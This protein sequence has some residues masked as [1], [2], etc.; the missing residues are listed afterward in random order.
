MLD[1]CSAP[2][3]KSIQI[4]QRLNNT[5][6]LVANE[7]VY[8]RAKILYENIVRFGYKNYIVSSNL[9]SVF[10]N[11]C[12]LY[13]KILIDAPCSG[14]GMFRKSS[15]D[16]YSWSM[17]NVEA[18]SNR[19]YEILQSVSKALKVGGKLVYSTCTY[20]IEE[21][22]KVV[23]RFL[24]ANPDYV[25][26]P[27]P[28]NVQDSTAR[29][30]DV[31]GEMTHMCGRRYP[32]LHKGEG[33]FVALMQRVGENKD[34]CPPSYPLASRKDTQYIQSVL[35]P[36]VDTSDMRFYT[37]GDNVYVVPD[38]DMDI[39]GM[40]VTSLGVYVGVVTKKGVDI[41]HSFYKAYGDRFYNKV[42]LSE[43]EANVYITGNV[44]DVPSANPGICAVLYKGVILG[45]GK[46]SNGVLKN[47]YPKNL[48]K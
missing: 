43:A 20:N 39:A 22:E 21:N 8:N 7:Y 1:V 16:T 31:D 48:R 24:K 37:K 2:G 14:E 29:G 6:L 3:G 41:S 33:Q 4:L 44:V 13:D 32:H 40:N 26:L 42:E 38:V 36:I 47:F 25:L 10:D 5:G 45:G 9:P 19:Q 34:I 28:D 12:Q 18:C 23:A 11:K 17:A 27:L 15:V 46:V 35:N 30:I